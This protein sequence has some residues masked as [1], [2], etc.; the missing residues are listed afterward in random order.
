MKPSSLLSLAIFFAVANATAGAATIHSFKKLHLEKYYWS[1]G[2]TF[3]DLNQDGRPDAI[4]GP[5]W[6]EGPNFTRRHEIYPPTMTFK[7]KKDDGT[8]ETLP[9]FEGAY[10]K[11]NAYS[12]DN[13]FSFAYDL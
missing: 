7:V 1:E 5:Y 9:G 8:E 3:G 4:S 6:W 10:G 13:F 2:A 12:T 11:Q